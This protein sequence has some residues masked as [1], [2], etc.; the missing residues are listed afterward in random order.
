M[1]VIGILENRLSASFGWLLRS[2]SHSAS[3]THSQRIVIWTMFRRRQVCCVRI[4]IECRM[5][6]LFFGYLHRRFEEIPS[7]LFFFRKFFECV[8]MMS[9]KTPLF[10]CWFVWRSKMIADWPYLELISQVY[11]WNCRLGTW[12]VASNRL[13]GLLGKAKEQRTCWI[14]CKVAGWFAIVS[15]CFGCRWLI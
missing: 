3:C 6:I 2:V 4:S 10:C 12:R 5:L 13:V 11:R 8:K 1:I 9:R 14:L 15:G 7:D